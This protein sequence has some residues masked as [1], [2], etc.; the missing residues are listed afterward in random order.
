GQEYKRIKNRCFC[1][2]SKDDNGTVIA[3]KD[4][5]GLP[6]KSI[7]CP[8]TG[9]ICSDSIFDEKSNNEFY[10]NEY[11]DLASFGISIPEYFDSQVNTRGKFFYRLF[12][13]H[14]KIDFGSKIVDIGCGAGG[15]LY[16]FLNN[17]NQC[18]GFDYDRDY[19]E[20][21]KTKGLDLRWGDYKDQIKDDSVDIVI[22]SHVMEHFLNP[23]QDIQDVI[24]IVKPNKYLIVEVPGIY[25]KYRKADTPL[26]YLQ[27]A[28][29]VNYFHYDFL[30]F[31][32]K[33]LNMEIV[34]GDERCTFILRKNQNWERIDAISIPGNLFEGKAGDIKSYLIKTHLSYNWNFRNLASRMLVSLG[35]VKFLKR[36]FRWIKKH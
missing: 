36:F 4:M 25:F 28:H 3:E 9:L 10:I 23:I 30:E 21:G 13:E 20:Y 18:I 29:V 24:E 16:S 35:F 32:F 22:L 15:V 14:V 17:K 31:L 34:Y 26:K 5:H 12:K 8:Q 1:N 27:I 7:L 11:R 6:L 19:L 2:C 33:K